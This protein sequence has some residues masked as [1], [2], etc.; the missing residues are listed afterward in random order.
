M[1]QEA[2]AA[3]GDHGHPGADAQTQEAVRG[4]YGPEGVVQLGEHAR[5]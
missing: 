3:Q 1:D 2:T 4:G 5:L